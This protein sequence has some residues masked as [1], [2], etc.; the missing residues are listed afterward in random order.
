MTAHSGNHRRPASA[1]ATGVNARCADGRRFCSLMPPGCTRG[2]RRARPR[3]TEASTRPPAARAR[4]TEAS[5]PAF[6]PRR[7]L[8]E[9]SAAAY[10]RG[11]FIC[12]RCTEIRE[13]VHNSDR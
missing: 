11:A 3:L 13:G 10:A 12:R 7:R 4:L 6:R 2:G 5:T 9:A 8:T 1:F